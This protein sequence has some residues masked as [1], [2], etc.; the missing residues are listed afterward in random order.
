MK[1]TLTIATALMTGAYA[2]SSGAQEAASLLGSLPAEV[3]KDIGDIRARCRVHLVNADET[4]V[5]SGDEGLEVFTVSGVQAVMIDERELCDGCFKGA[6][7]SNRGSY[8]VTIYLR[9]GKAWRKALSTE[10]TGSVFLSTDR[11]KDPAAFKALVLNVFGGNKDCPT[12]DIPL[13]RVGKERLFLPAWKQSCA[14]VV[15]WNGTKFTYKPL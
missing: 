15:K 10:A 4:R 8:D 7:C 9:S 12:R 13:G 2:L 14:A 5:S 11:V 6:N 1:I 3:Q